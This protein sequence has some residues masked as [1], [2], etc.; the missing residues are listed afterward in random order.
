[1]V[2]VVLSPL[3]FIIVF[4]WILSLFFLMSLFK[5]LLILFIFS[6]N[7]LLDSLILRI[8]LLVSLSF[9]SAL[10]LVISFLLLALGCLC[11]CSSSSCRHRVRLFELFLTSYGRPVLLWTSLSGRPL[12]CPIGFGLLWVRFHLFQKLFDLF[13]NLIVDPFIV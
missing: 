8:V 11:C 7:Q 13:P 5:G 1:M 3:S 2:S 10:I 6:K 9:N 4:I 12:L